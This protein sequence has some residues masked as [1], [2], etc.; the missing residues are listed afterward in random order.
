MQNF[1]FVIKH[2]Y[3]NANKVVEALSRKI[4]ILQEFQIKTLG[5]ITLRKCITVIQILEKHMKHV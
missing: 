4:L 5:L 1:T 3:G 2:I